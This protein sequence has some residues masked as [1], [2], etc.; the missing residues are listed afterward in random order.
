M[1]TVMF[2]LIPGQGRGR[3]AIQFRLVEDD[4]LPGVVNV[5]L[6]IGDQSG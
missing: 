1:M 6:E 5:F 2:N 4:L 3:Y